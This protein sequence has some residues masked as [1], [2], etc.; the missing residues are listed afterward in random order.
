MIKKLTISF[1]KNYERRKETLLRFGIFY[2]LKNSSGYVL[3]I[4]LLITSMLVS[5]STEFLITA[6][7]NINYIKKFSDRLQALSIAKSGVSLSSFLL[8]ADKRGLSQM[9]LGQKATKKI[10]C[11]EDVWAFD[12]PEIPLE[13]GS[14]KLDISDENSKINL[15][16]LANEYAEKTMYYTITERLITN[17]GLPMDLANAILDWVDIND[18]VFQY[19]AESSDYYLTLETPYNAKNNA[20]DSI[21]ELL[22]IKGITPEIFYGMSEG[23]GIEENLV[24]DNKGNRKVDSTFLGKINPDNIMESITETEDDFSDLAMNIGREKSRQLSDYFRVHGKRNDFMDDL[25]KININTASF[26]VLSALTENENA[27]IDIA[28]EIISRRNSKPIE[29]INDIE[30]LIQD[31]DF[32]EKYLT[33]KSYIF[34]IISIGT[35]NDTSIKITCIYYRDGKKFLYW[36]EQ[37]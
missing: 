6:Q 2:Y 1:L 14:L 35:V 30:D 32:R 19:G 21:D 37:Y 25:N 13:N 28:T 9:F 11:Y 10:D 18:T 15:S 26:R 31:K 7:V 24:D 4:I 34:K 27:D 36:N 8:M 33:I 3:I 12:F 29:S 16:I 22:L 23:Y 20:M 5:I 17:M